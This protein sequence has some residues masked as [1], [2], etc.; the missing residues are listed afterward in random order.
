MEFNKRTAV[1]YECGSGTTTVNLEDEQVE[2]ISV[3]H[4]GDTP[5]NIRVEY[6]DGRIIR[7]P[8]HNVLYTEDS[9]S[10]SAEDDN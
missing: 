10:N 9:S 2:D 4:V 7:I 1:H 5:V 6:E 8:W 3:Q